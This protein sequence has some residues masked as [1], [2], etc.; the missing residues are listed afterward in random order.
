MASFFRRS[1]SSQLVRICGGSE[2]MFIPLLSA[3]PV[4]KKQWT[5]E[6]RLSVSALVCSG[7][8]SREEDVLTQTQRLT[9][10]LKVDGVIE[11]VSA[12]RGV[13]TFRVN[14]LLLAQKVLSE[15][16]EDPQVNSDLLRTLP[17]GRTLVEYSSPN[18]AKKF[19]AGHLRSTI[20]GNFIANLKQALGNDVI[21]VNYLGDWGMQFG[22]LG[23]GFQRLGSQ[24]KLKENALQHLFEVYVQVNKEAEFDESV[25]LDAAEFYRRLEQH[26]EQ[27]LLLWK[28]FREITVQEYKRI[29]QRL[30]VHFD[31]YSGESFHQSKAQEVL[32]DL[33][34]QGLLKT[35]EKGTG[36]VDLSDQGDMSSYS[37]VVRSDGT[38]LYITRDVAAALERKQ[39]FGFDEMIYVTDK[40]QSVHFQQLFQILR[41]MG[42][43]WANRCVHV[44]F[45]LVKGM[46]TRRGDVVFLEDVMDEAQ[47]RMMHN[48]SQSKT[49]KVV[50]D[51]ELTADQIGISAII[52]QDFKG[53]LMADYVFDWERVLQAQGDTGVFLQYTHARLRSLLRTH[54]NQTLSHFNASHLQDHRSISILQHLLRYDEVLLQSVLELQPRNLVNFLLTLCH[55]VS[56]AHRDLPVKGSAADVAQARLHLFT[57]TCSVLASGM[58]ILGVTPVEK[59]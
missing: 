59:M 44:P 51:P 14:K 42:H 2:E 36:V 13:I 6:F 34:T 45:G 48:M 31:H 54:G 15:L 16:R 58:K 4:S 57:V 29:Y 47:N 8:I 7:I 35:T 10:Q 20:I 12:G 56:A 21:R 30:G 43:D 33:R 18:I 37:T 39:T 26:E 46:S 25:L 17:R 9:K 32:S 5:P 19:H 50:S 49:S 22:L 55:L 38:S 40:S 3:V 1:V 28:Q 52:I 24:E 11:D 27:A 41:V 53:P 23:A